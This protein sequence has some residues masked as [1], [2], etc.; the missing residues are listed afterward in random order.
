ME[1]PTPAESPQ[2]VPGSSGAVLLIKNPH[3]RERVLET[4]HE[5]LA[6]IHTIRLQAMHEMGSVRELDRTLAHTLMA[7]F[8]RLHLIIG[9]DLTKSSIT[10]CTNLETSCEV[11]ASDFARILNL[12]P[13]DPTSPQVKAIIQKFQQTTSIK[14]DLPL[15][16]LGAAREDLEEFFQ[17]C[18]HEISS[19]SESHE[20]IEELSQKLLV[21]TSRIQ[22][23]VQAPELDE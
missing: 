17:N 16:E 21:H 1:A 22:E 19:Q 14:L 13:N 20:V 15:M 5:I 2:P 4:A 10:V 9:E 12:H 3:P 11:L 7:E 8:S 18:L 6:C 23:V